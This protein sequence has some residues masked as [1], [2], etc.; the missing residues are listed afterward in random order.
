MAQSGQTGRCAPKWIERKN[1][2]SSK[3]NFSASEIGMH[4]NRYVGVG[5]AT[6]RTGNNARQSDLS[7]I[8]C[9]LP[10]SPS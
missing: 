5:S 4:I 9:L 8:T 1:F 6:F 10:I 7:Q 2:S 3:I